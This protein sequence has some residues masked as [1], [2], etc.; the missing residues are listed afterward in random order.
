MSLEE[1]EE[2]TT[3]SGFV[4]PD[5]AAIHSEEIIK[6]KVVKGSKQFNDGLIVY[7]SRFS[8]LPLSNKDSKEQLL[9]VPESD[10]MAYETDEA[11]YVDK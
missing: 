3:A 5:S 8:V 6:A 10:V 11:E 2:K 7:C 9:I 1:N 4:L